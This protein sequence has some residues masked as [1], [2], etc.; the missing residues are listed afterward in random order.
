MRDPFVFSKSARGTSDVT[1]TQV[2]VYEAPV[3]CSRVG[4]RDTV[5]LIVCVS[6]AGQSLTTQ[7]Q[8]LAQLQ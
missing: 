5:A 4:R 8:Q 1:S 6:I 7:A 3:L 2:K